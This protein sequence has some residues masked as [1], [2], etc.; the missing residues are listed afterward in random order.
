MDIHF[1]KEY[2]SIP[3]QNTIK[4]PDC[5]VLAGKNGSGKTHL[6]EGIKNGDFVIDEIGIDDILLFDYTKFSCFRWC[7][8]CYFS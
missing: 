6:L 8:W 4:L 1:N 5:F 3:Q 7:G 2:K